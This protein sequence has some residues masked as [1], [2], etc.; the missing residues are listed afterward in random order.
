MMT[1]RKPG[2]GRPNCSPVPCLSEELVSS[3]RKITRLTITILWYVYLRIQ[4]IDSLKNTMKVPR[5]LSATIRPWYG[6]GG[7]FCSWTPQFLCGSSNPQRSIILND[8]PFYLPVCMP[9]FL[10][11]CLSVAIEDDWTFRGKYLHREQQ[12]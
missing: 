2:R 6:W 9:A 5:R 3:P 12:Q 7:K 8:C 1:A 10:L 4:S 11:L